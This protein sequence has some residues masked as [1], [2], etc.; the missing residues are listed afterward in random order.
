M[1]NVVGIGLDGGKGLSE[2]VLE[3][4]DD[5]TVLV[6]GDRHL[7]YFPNHSGIKLKIGDLLEVIE[8]IR[9]YQNQQEKIVIL[10]SGDPLFFG[11]GRFLLTKFSREE[12]SFY[13]HL[14]SV[15]LAFNKLKIP[16]QDVSIVSIHGRDFEE[17]ISVLKQGKDKI[18]ILTDPLHNP[19]TI[20]ELYENLALAKKYDF[21]V[22][23]NLGDIDEG[24][25]YF[26]LGK[27][28]KLKTFSPLNIVILIS[29]NQEQKEQLNIDELPLLGI[30]DD[31]FM[32]FSDRIGLMTKREIRL[33]ILGELALQPNQIIWDLGAG[34]G[35]V[36]IEIAR[37]SPSS[38]VYAIEKTAMG[39]TLI[40]K[41]CQLFQV[42]NVIPIHGVAPHILGEL[43]NA[44]R[45]FIGGS[46]GNLTSILDFCQQKL[47][48]NGIIVLALATLEN[49]QESINWFKTHN[50]KYQILQVQ[51]SRSIPVANLTR[52]TPL[53][54]VT[55]IRGNFL[56][57]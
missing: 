4:I 8:K 33:I 48:E 28:L 47:K 35:S 22:A 56:N 51:I 46:G 19:A 53:N 6:G 14:T 31:K 40:E 7:S 38:H 25:S 39:I 41:N 16:W 21:W 5:A 13:P 12:L 20:V 45:I 42:E 18:A 49:Q 34:T 37:L 57:N 9:N 17:L 36:S 29:S 55:I 11:L 3:I 44:D 23:E 30:A 26:P 43:P 27:D 15:Q 52:F 1:I 32:S 10:T 24:L 50:W 2:K 54:P